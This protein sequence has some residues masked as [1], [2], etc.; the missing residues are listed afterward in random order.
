MASIANIE[1]LAGH[2][3]LDF[4][5][6]VDDRLGPRPDEYLRDAGELA[7]WGV[8]GGVARGPPRPGR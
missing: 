1:L 7:A 3:A 4:L 6:T 2:P 8:A 5:N